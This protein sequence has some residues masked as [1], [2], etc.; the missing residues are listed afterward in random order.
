MHTKAIPL[1]LVNR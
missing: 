1:T